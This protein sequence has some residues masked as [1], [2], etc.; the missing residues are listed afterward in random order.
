[1]KF[2]DSLIGAVYESP[3]IDVLEIS[4]EGVLCDSGTERLDEIDGA[5]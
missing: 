4:P 5:W 3:E 1:M 2:I